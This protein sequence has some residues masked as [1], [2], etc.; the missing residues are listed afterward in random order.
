MYNKFHDMD[1][2]KNRRSKQR[3]ARNYD[4][5]K[6]GKSFKYKKNELKK[7]GFG[8]NKSWKNKINHTYGGGEKKG[9]RKRFNNNN[10]GNKDY[11]N[12]SGSNVATVTTTGTMS[13]RKPICDFEHMLDNVVEN[14]ISLKKTDEHFILNLKKL[15]DINQYWFSLKKNMERI[16]SKYVLKKKKKNLQYDNINFYIKKLKKRQ[17]KKEKTNENDETFVNEDQEQK[18]QPESSQQKLLFLNPED[19]LFQFDEENKENTLNCKIWK[20]KIKHL[21]KKRISS[22][23]EK[24]TTTSQSVDEYTEKPRIIDISNIPICLKQLYDLGNEY[25]DSN[26]NSMEMN[27]TTTNN[28]NYHRGNKIKLKLLL[29]RKLNMSSIYSLLYDIGLNLMYEYYTIYI[30]KYSEDDEKIHL[31]IIHNKSNIFSD[32]INNMVV[33]FKKNPLVYIM[34]IKVLLDFYKKREDVFIKKSILECLKHVFIFVLPNENLETV[35][36]NNKTVMNYILNILFNRFNF[37]EYNFSSYYFFLNSLLYIYAF[38]N[39]TKKLFLQYI[40]ILKN[41]I[42]SSIPSVFFVSANNLNEFCLKK[43]EN[44]FA[45]LNI[46]LDGY[47]TINK[48]NPLLLNILKHIITIDYMKRYVM[49]YCFEQILSNLRLCVEQIVQ[50]LKIG[51]KENIINEKLKKEIV[52]MNRCLYVLYKMKTN[53]FNDITENIIYFT[54]YIFEMFSKNVFELNDKKNILLKEWSI[55]KMSYIKYVPI[56]TENWENKK[57]AKNGIRCATNVNLGTENSCHGNKDSGA[58]KICT[59]ELEERSRN[60]ELYKKENAPNCSNG[61]ATNLMG[62]LRNFQTVPNDNSWSMGSTKETNMIISEDLQ[63]DKNKKHSKRHCDEGEMKRETEE[64]VEDGEMRELKGRGSKNWLQNGYLNGVQ[65]WP[66]NER[67]NE[68]QNEHQNGPQNGRKH[69]DGKKKTTEETLLHKQCLYGYLSKTILKLLSSIL[70]NNI[71][72]I[73]YNRCILLKNKNGKETGSDDRPSEDKYLHSLNF[74]SLLK[75]IK[76]VESYKIKINFLTIMFLLLYSSNQIDDNI[77]CYFYSILKNMNYYENEHTY[78]FYGLLTVLILTD[79]NL[80]RN[81][82]FIKRIFQRSIHSKESC[83]HLFSLMMIRYLVF[84][85]NILMK[86]LYNDENILYTHNLDYVKNSYIV[87][88]N[89]YHKGEKNVLVNDKIFLYDES[90]NNPLDANSVLTHFYEFYNFSSMLNDNFKNVLFEFRNI[91]IFNYNFIQM[92][93]YSQHK[94]SLSYNGFLNSRPLLRNSCEKTNTTDNS[95]KENLNGSAGSGGSLL[96]DDKQ[97][98]NNADLFEKNCNE[99]ISGGSILGI[100]DT[101]KQIDQHIMDN[102]NG[103]ERGHNN[104]SYEKDHDDDIVINIRNNRQWRRK[105]Q[106]NDHTNELNEGEINSVLLPPTKNEATINHQANNFTQHYPNQYPPEPPMNLYDCSNSYYHMYDYQAKDVINILDK[107]SLEY[108]NAQQQVNMLNIF[109]NFIHDSCINE[110][111]EGKEEIKN[112]QRFK[113]MNNPYQKY[114]YDILNTY[115][116]NSFKKFKDKYQIKRKKQEAGEREGASKSNDID[117]DDD[118]DDDGSGSLIDEEQ[119]EDDFLDDYIAKNFDIGKDLDDDMDSPNKMSHKKKKRKKS[120]QDNFSKDKNFKKNSKKKKAQPS[121]APTDGVM[122]F[123]DFAK[124][125][126]KKKGRIS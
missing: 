44:K 66:Q 56:D 102:G 76:S 83:T 119:E 60:G 47:I 89:K 8:I 109:N 57:E 73:I 37:K 97:L 55:E 4:F 124:L 50:S 71:Y 30:K 93:K 110:K 111:S 82:S 45:N 63:E 15:Y 104:N 87:K 112:Q 35:E 43:K 86:F 53:S 1:Q 5:K 11:I 80:I 69:E 22:C 61:N 20:K 25:K 2:Q 39:Y 117:N 16:V 90:V 40:Y 103:I 94:N 54:T 122:E 24:S 78:N 23:E 120:E 96:V 100:K 74:L 31:E 48:G 114:F 113:L 107:L 38:E 27:N 106:I 62:M 12:R 29:K 32:R 41:G 14:K 105:K 101:D 65:N 88:F 19:I 52:S 21:L 49:F 64:R 18:Y 34:Y 116:N 13:N 33:L 98:S 115:N 125:K 28:N 118:H 77:Y 72:F 9:N 70:V 92:K 10:N 91:T 126:S 123:S 7:R 68:P 99:R 46:L 84:K 58:N 79:R 17:K 6:T 36:E 108:K 95:A 51:D 75:I 3:D 85:K 121:D 59:R 42:Y 81:V 26:N 67:Q